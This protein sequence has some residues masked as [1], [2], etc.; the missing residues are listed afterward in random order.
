MEH[1]VEL[2]PVSETICDFAAHPQADLIVIGARGLSTA[3]RILLGSV[4]QQVVLLAH[5]TALVWRAHS[6]Q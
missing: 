3:K 6:A 1:A 4:S 5:C 2:G